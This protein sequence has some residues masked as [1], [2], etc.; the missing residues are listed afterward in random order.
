[1]VHTTLDAIYRAPSEV[2]ISQHAVHNTPHGDADIE[3]ALRANTRPLVSSRRVVFVALLGLVGAATAFVCVVAAASSKPIETHTLVMGSLPSLALVAWNAAKKLAA[4]VWLS[5]PAA[6]AVTYLLVKQ[7]ALAEVAIQAGQII[8]PAIDQD[9]AV[10]RNHRTYSG[11]H[12]NIQDCPFMAS[13]GQPFARNTFA[14]TSPNLSFPD[15]DLVANTFFTRTTFTPAT[16]LNLFV[17]AWIQFVVHDLLNHVQ[18]TATPPLQVGSQTIFRTKAIAPGVFPNEVDHYLDGSQLYGGSAVAGAVL[19]QDDG[20]LRL[21]NDYL[22]MNGTTKTEALGLPI[23]QWYGLSMVTYIMALEHNALVDMFHAKYPAWSGNECFERARL[24][25]SALI[26]KIQ[27]LE[28]TKAI[29]QNDAGHFAQD[30]MFYGFLGKASRKAVGVQRWL[31]NS[32]SGSW[33]GKLTYEGN[34]PYATTEEFTSVYR[35]HSLLPEAITVRS[36]A[37]NKALAS[38]PL[39][40]GIF[41]GSARVNL[42]A[43][44][45]DMVYSLGVNHPGALVLNNFPTAL[46]NVNPQ[47]DYSHTID[48]AA[49][50]IIR[51]RERGVPRYNAFRRSLLLTPISTWADLTNDVEVQAK[52]Q[53]V[54]GSDVELL[55]LLVGT[56]AEKKLPG[57]V[58][59]ETIYTVFVVQT[60]RRI[61][62]DRFFTD[63]Y[64]PNV[65]T[66]E[67]YDWVENTTFAS[68]L[69]RHFPS[70]GRVLAAQDNAFMAWKNV[71]P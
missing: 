43:S 32:V 3:V 36:A 41:Q 54:Y 24:V 23:N 47:G 44:R 40:Q 65:Y 68:I 70:L 19:R 31:G 9:A 52:L 66:Q 35:M 30:H 29:I 58:F 57:F 39:A 21:P 26:A 7:Q 18:D 11:A 2:A 59:G 53:A 8:P 34:V 69:L 55:D 49:V 1:M 56:T 63:D 33:G 28:W 46:R 16:A 15:P 10:P 37:T 13:R 4:D 67:G 71:T 17:P 25:I 50:D 64:R 20:K 22:V 48:L 14:V 60:A 5:G 51:D 42:N 38:V 12:N 62:S 27:G 61:E 6:S 45:V